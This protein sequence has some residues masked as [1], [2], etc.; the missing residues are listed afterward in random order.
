VIPPCSETSG[1][2]IACRFTP[3]IPVVAR[4]IAEA[5]LSRSDLSYPLLVGKPE[6][7]CCPAAH[8]P[9][10]RPW[11]IQLPPCGIRNLPPRSCP[12]VSICESPR[13][14]RGFPLW[15]PDSYPTP[16]LPAVSTL[17]PLGFRPPS[18][19]IYSVVQPMSPKVPPRSPKGSHSPRTCMYPGMPSLS[20]SI[21]TRSK[22]S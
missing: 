14:L 20:L 21:C 6:I 10:S 12:R 11:G 22:N 15:S 4:G 13:I 5:T 16:F 9:P 17:Y 1:P 3:R 8:R 2:D 18:P 19:R 7:P